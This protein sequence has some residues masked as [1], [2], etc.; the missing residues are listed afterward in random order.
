M[1]AVPALP[2]PPIAAQ[3]L[4]DDRQRLLAALTEGLDAGALLY[5]SGYA[6]GL[7]A[8][9]RQSA[10]APAAAFTVGARATVLHASH[11]GNGRRIAEKLVA[12]LEARGLT[13]R[14]LAAGDYATRELAQE[15]LL[16]VIASTHGDGDPPDGARPFFDFLLG[17]KAPRLDQLQYAVLALG[18]SSYPKFCEAGRIADERLAALGATAIGARV[19]CDLDYEHAAANWSEAALQHALEAL[20]P[21]ADAP[22]L[23]LVSPLRNATSA[24]ATPAVATRDAPVVAE[25]LARQRITGRASDHP[26]THLEIAAPADRLAYVPGDALGVWHRNPAFVAERIADVLQLD[27]A[28][29]VTHA[30]EQRPLGDWLTDHRE[31][32]RLS[33]PMLEAHAARS[34]S[35]SLQALVNGDAQERAAAL[36]D[37]Q[38]LDLLETHPA[39]WSPEDLVGALR[40]LAPRLYS[41]ASS[42]LEVGDELHLTVAAVEY[43]RAGARRVGTASHFLGSDTPELRVYVEPNP[44]FRLPADGDRDLIMIGAGTG[45]APYRGFLQQRGAE[46]ARGRHWLLFGARRFSSDFLYQAEWLAAR[47]RGLLHRLDLAASRDQAEKVYVQ[48]RLREQGAELWRWIEGGASIYVCGDA[49]HMAPDVH[50][51]LIDVAQAHGG[52]SAASAQTWIGELVAAR[53][54]LRDVY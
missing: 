50:A 16:Y 13:A 1:S 31:I 54:Y 23:A 2:L 26:V 32:T 40:P 39:A 46:G 22:R 11:T 10:P 14:A 37:W 20:K 48:H 38:L 19:D 29:S 3:P 18:D 43:E 24:I 30:G 45:V 28:T 47:K 51:A 5:V 35:P 52:H 44:H 34:H 8:A 42:R 53:R 9:R 17:R 6:A 36:R 25:V 7:A 41:I 33:R 12:T 27:L 49:T 4:P 21:A 15:R